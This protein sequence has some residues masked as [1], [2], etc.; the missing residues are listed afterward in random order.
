MQMVRYR[1][2]KIVTIVVGLE[3]KYRCSLPRLSAKLEERY[4]KTREKE[5]EDEKEKE[6]QLERR[7][8]NMI[9]NRNTTRRNE[10]SQLRREENLE[11]IH[12]S[13]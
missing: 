12:G 9:K 4:W 7:M 2:Q 13:Q 6:K 11:K 5:G 3:W 8:I 10:Q 1:V